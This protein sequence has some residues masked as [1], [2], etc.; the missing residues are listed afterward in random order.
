MHLRSHTRAGTILIFV[1]GLTTV[2]I[3]IAFGLLRSMQIDQGSSVTQRK[4]ALSR[5]A[6]E[7]GVQHATAVCLHEYA[8]QEDIRDNA[9]V[10]AHARI[11]GPHTNVFNLLAQCT[12]SLRKQSYDMPPDLPFSDMYNAYTG[13]SYHLSTTRMNGW[14]DGF[15]APRTYARLFEANRFDYS[16]TVAYDSA[17]YNR[18]VPA[19]PNP[20][21]VI[22]PF[23]PVEPFSQV[24]SITK[25]H[26]LDNPILYDADFRPVTDPNRAR[27]RLRY[28]VAVHDLSAGFWMNT[29]MPWLGNSAKAASRSTHANAV[30]AVGSVLGYP[31]VIESVFLGQGPATNNLFN[32]SGAENP[33]VPVEWPDRGGAAMNYRYPN[34]RGS[35]SFHCV[36]GSPY[37]RWNDPPGKWLGQSLMSWNDLAFAAE[38][39]DHN[40][41]YAGE[42]YSN[43]SHARGHRFAHWLATPFGR[44]YDAFTDHP[45]CINPLGVSTKTLQAMVMAYLPPA[46]R[47]AQVTTETQSPYIRYQDGSGNWKAEFPAGSGSYGAY[48]WTVSTWSI[49][50]AARVTVPGPGMDLFTDSF[51][52]TATGTKLFNYPSVP[53]IDYW[54][55]NPWYNRTDT[56]LPADARVN[57]NR[58]P[59][60]LFFSS[61]TTEATCQQAIRWKDVTSEPRQVESDPAHTPV[62]PGLGTDHTGRHIVFYVKDNSV[63]TAAVGNTNNIVSPIASGSAIVNSNGM[64]YPN[65]PYN[66]GQSGAGTDGRISFYQGSNYTLYRPAVPVPVNSGETYPVLPAPPDDVIAANTAPVA[67][68][69]LTTS[70]FNTLDPKK[71]QITR[72]GSWG[73]DAPTVIPN[74]YWNRLGVAF[75]H[76]ILVTQVAHMSWADTSDTRNQTGRFWLGGNYNCGITYATSPGPMHNHYAL[77]DVKVR[78]GLASFKH[79]SDPKVADSWDPRVADFSTMEQVDRQFLANLGESFD[80]PGTVTPG[81][82][83]TIIDPTTTRPRPARFTRY[84]SGAG[85]DPN[86]VNYC[87]PTPP[88]IGE[89]LV[90][91]NIRTLLT[92]INTALATLTPLSTAPQTG[93]NVP[94]GKTWLLDEWNCQGDAGYTPGT[95]V[96]TTP[97]LV[98]RARA[99]LMERVLNDWRLSFLGSAAS[100]AATFLPKDFDG[101]GKVF[102]S[103]YT[104]GTS[105]DSDTGLTCWEAV[106]A[107]G[108]GPGILSTSLE[109]FSVTG[110]FSLMRSHQYKIMS[111]GELYDN[112]L[113]KVASEFH[114]E[115]ALLLDPDNNVNRTGLPSGVAD[116]VI[117]TQRPFHNYIRSL[118]VRSY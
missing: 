98:A 46:I 26:P 58:Y 41:L 35:K 76:A 105:V 100:Y 91:N 106:V 49:P 38:T 6:A 79:A 45:W 14:I 75:C 84:G 74:S 86:Y 9:S 60:E 68:D 57:S 71:W 52:S 1:V 88:V 36:L 61:S 13:G 24:G 10:T 107:S 40:P 18:Y 114:L 80:N 113:G 42:T 99:K 51:I 66:L 117:L 11:D 92:P 64:F 43:E 83:A 22:T 72:S 108:N 39:T 44:P 55:T 23:P 94:P 96:D 30:E 3:A 28:A 56:T 103:G 82:A 19:T 62:A 69:T 70:T 17:S 102:C 34:A 65:S 31:S 32:Q 15:L 63:Q 59:G 4:D 2:M 20:A 93:G 112:Y 48:T 95:T 21:S 101:D 8:M 67:R 27:Y 110:C 33:G 12:T 90:T 118:M 50:V 97:T 73:A 25:A 87:F 29:D 77:P 16:R 78:K 111:R 53:Y 5:L 54:K 37:M 89:Y 116:S 104:K 85:G 47:G 109:L 115:S 81:Q 7:M